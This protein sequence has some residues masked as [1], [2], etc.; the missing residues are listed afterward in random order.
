MLSSNRGA[1][2]SAMTL[3]A[4]V[5]RDLTNRSRSRGPHRRARQLDQADQQPACFHTDLREQL[6][7]DLGLTP[8]ELPYAGE[9]LDVIDD[10]SQWRGAAERVLRGFA[11]FAGPQ[12][13]YDEVAR[14]V[15]GRRLSFP[16]PGRSPDRHETGLRTRSDR[17]VPLR[18]TAHD[19]LIL[20]DCLETKAGA[21]ADYLADE[22]IRR[23]D[24][25]CV[26]TLAQFGQERRAVTRE[27]QVRSGERH[28]KDDRTR[29]DDP[30]TW[31]LGWANERKIAALHEELAQLEE[32]ERAAEKSWREVEAERRPPS[33]ASMRSPRL[34]ASRRGVSWTS[35]RHENALPCKRKRRRGSRPA[36]LDLRRSSSPSDA[37]RS[38]KTT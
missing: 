16:W 1:A 29:V 28:E 26:D 32:T 35:W 6:C 19:H 11:L 34:P 31:V 24:Y 3:P 23:A 4:F 10:Q 37:W 33:N 12:V 36:R 27:G 14:W 7:K 30:R 8:E 17:R 25:R 22:L 13:H 2:R 9:L 5:G 21:F 20:A 38:S 15:N 18:P